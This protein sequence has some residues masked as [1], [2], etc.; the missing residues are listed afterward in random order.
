MFNSGQTVGPFFEGW[1]RNDDGSFEFYFGYINRNYV[2]ELHVP[3]GANNRVEPGAPDQGQPTFFYPR[4]HKRVF[5]VQ[6]PSDFGDQEFIWTISTRG[7]QHRAVGWLQ[8]EWEIAPDAFSAFFAGGEG[9]NANRAPTLEIDGARTVGT[10]ESLSLVAT[11]ADDGLPEPRQ[12]RGGGQATP[13]TLE[14]DLD[15]PTVPVN[16]PTLLPENRSRPTRVSVDNVSVVWTQL[17]GATGVSL[18]ADGEPQNGKAAFMATFQEPGEY[19]FR[20]VASDRVL[21]ASEE[22]TITVSR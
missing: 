5:G 7:E 2:E 1:S 19:V 15:G 9:E 11:V 13:P 8:P 14:D 12:R 17:R 4:I 6:V 21:S 18:R 3:I 22:I 10:G 16:V 20:V